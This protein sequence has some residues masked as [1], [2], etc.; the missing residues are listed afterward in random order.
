MNR[1]TII[2]AAMAAATVPLLVLNI[3]CGA[4]DIPIDAVAAISVGL[5]G[6][7]AIL[8]LPY[9]EDKDA[10]VDA[11]IVMTGS[12]RFVEVQMSGE[13]ATFDNEQLC[14]LLALAKKGISHI[15]QLQQKAIKEGLE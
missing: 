2:N 10:D 13:E 11:N 8:D 4:V 14:D 9:A 5:L 12:G 7:R 3:A 15:L 1:P 6:D